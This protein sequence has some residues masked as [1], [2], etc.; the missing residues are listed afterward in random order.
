M[1][2][3]LRRL[4]EAYWIES[5]KGT[6]EAT[7][8]VISDKRAALVAAAALS[9]KSCPGSSVL[10]ASSSSTRLGMPVTPVTPFTD[11]SQLEGDDVIVRLWVLQLTEMAVAVEPERTDFG[12]ATYLDGSRNGPLSR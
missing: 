8:G 5:A 11:N 9:R 10:K 7:L 4:S 1:L 12:V 2:E 6:D 3:D